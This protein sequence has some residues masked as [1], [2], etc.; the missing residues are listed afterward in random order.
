MTTL[1][2]DVQEKLG[3]SRDEV[4]REWVPQLDLSLLNSTSPDSGDFKEYLRL[5]LTPMDRTSNSSSKPTPETQQPLLNAMK[6]KLQ[7]MK[8]QLTETKLPGFLTRKEVR[9]D[10]SIPQEKYSIEEDHKQEVT[11]AGLTDHQEIGSSGDKG[12]NTKESKCKKK[13][14]CKSVEMTPSIDGQNTQMSRLSAIYMK[15]FRAMS[16]RSKGNKVSPLDEKKSSCTNTPDSVDSGMHDCNG[17]TGVRKNCRKENR[18]NKRRN[19]KATSQVPCCNT[20]KPNLQEIGGRAENQTSARASFRS[21]DTEKKE[22][23][24][25]RVKERPALEAVTKM[26]L[27]ENVNV[28]SVECQ[29][30]VKMVDRA[31]QTEFIHTL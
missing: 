16:K 10:P 28:E 6:E 1:S 8:K 7:G 18:A 13:T 26:N 22:I 15:P 31:T 29:C 24:D 2:T 14:S 27:Q 12:K 3:S 23:V 9:W 11:K 5:S 4:P 17:Q 19:S 30:S 20:Q 21:N 25:R